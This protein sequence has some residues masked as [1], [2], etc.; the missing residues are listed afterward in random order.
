M[1]ADTPSTLNSLIHSV[2][3]C[4]EAGITA[5]KLIRARKCLQPPSRLNRPSDLQ[6]L[7]GTTGQETRFRL[8]QDLKPCRTCLEAAAISNFGEGA[9]SF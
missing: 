5:L 1:V 7:A 4:Y 6:G 9:A 8:G 2:H 3:N